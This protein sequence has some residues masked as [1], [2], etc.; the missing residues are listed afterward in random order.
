MVK[1]AAILFGVVFLLIGILGFVPAITPANGMLLAIFHV[2]TAHNIVHLA[3]GVVFLLCGIAGT[4]ASRTFF[5][6]FGFIYALVA[7]LRFYYGD[8]PIL[9]LIASNTADTGCMLCSQ[10]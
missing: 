7:L 10:S 2:N 1:T 9:G 3:S 6:I 5:R 4:G 8:N